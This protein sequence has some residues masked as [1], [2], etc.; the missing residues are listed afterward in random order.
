MTKSQLREAFKDFGTIVHAEVPI[1][2]RGRSKGY[3]VVLFEDK[4]QAEEAI[5]TMD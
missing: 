4:K 3:G 2:D 5:R 1:D